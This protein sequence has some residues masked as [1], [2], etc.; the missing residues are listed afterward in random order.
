MANDLSMRES[1]N[2]IRSDEEDESPPKNDLALKFIAR[3]RK[4]PQNM[5][6]LPKLKKPDEPDF[7][8][9]PEHEEVRF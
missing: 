1:L 9:E 7:S 4:R 6:D 3:T 2:P 5:K 8:A